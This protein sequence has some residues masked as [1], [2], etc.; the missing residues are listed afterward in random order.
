MTPARPPCPHATD[1][2]PSDD[3]ARAALYNRACALS[4]L[5]RFD[6]AAEDLR[7]ACVDTG[8]VQTR[9]KS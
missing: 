5:A 2:A 3:E 1:A 7:K 9:H 4:A 6:D 8:V